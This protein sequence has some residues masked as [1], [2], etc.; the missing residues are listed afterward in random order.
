MCHSCYFRDHI[1]LQCHLKL[2]Q[3]DMVLNNYKTL[4]PDERKMVPYIP[5][6][7]AEAYWAIKETN[8]RNVE[9]NR[10]TEPKR[11]VRGFVRSLGSIVRNKLRGPNPLSPTSPPL[12]TPPSIAF[13]NEVYANIEQ[14][15]GATKR[16]VV[17]LYTG[18][19]SRFIRL[20]ELPERLRA[21]IRK[22]GLHTRCSKRNQ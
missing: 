19:G 18:V 4:N 7:N 2:Y 14:P 9:Q 21:K 10:N 1:S 8:N 3:L 22:I 13:G 17:V 20:G 12:P 11:L 15:I 6:K 16:F 5:Y